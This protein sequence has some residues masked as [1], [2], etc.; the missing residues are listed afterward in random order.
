MIVLFFFVCIFIREWYEVMVGKLKCV[1]IGIYLLV[2]MI[3]MFILINIKGL[4][5]IGFLKICNLCF[6]LL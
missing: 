1:F 5:I 6:N 2:G 3:G 4:R